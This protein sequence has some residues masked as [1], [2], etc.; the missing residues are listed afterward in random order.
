MRHRTKRSESLWLKLGSWKPHISGQVDFDPTVSPWIFVPV[1]NTQKKPHPFDLVGGVPRNQNWAA[2]DALFFPNE[3]LKKALLERTNLQCGSDRS[4]FDKIQWKSLGFSI[5]H[6]S[7]ILFL[8]RCQKHTFLFLQDWVGESYLSSET[9][10]DPPVISLN[11]LSSS[12]PLFVFVRTP[13]AL[14]GRS[15]RCFL[16]IEETEAGSK[17]RSL[18][19]WGPG[20]H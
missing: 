2:N 10:Q 12:T 5:D 7:L 20:N 6:L 11:F 8:L 13:L 4:R 17:W 3:H 14:V 16:K 9:F 1:C 18:K 15:P 19:S